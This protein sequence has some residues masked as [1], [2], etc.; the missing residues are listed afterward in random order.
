MSISSRCQRSISP[1]AAIAFALG[2]IAV[3]AAPD[4]V[5]PPKQELL[6]QHAV[7]QMDEANFDANVF[8]P[9]GNA[10]MARDQIEIR[11]KLQMDEL[12]RICELNDVQKQKLKLAATSDIKRFFDEVN[13]I[14]KKVVSGK[15]DQNEWNNVWQE[16]QPLRNKQ[17]AGL[18]GESSFYS[19]TVRKTLNPDQFA[20]Y[21]SVRDERRRFRYHACVEAAITSL[22]STIPLRQ[23]QHEAIARFLLETTEP[24]LVFTQYDST[25]ILY[26]LT[27]MPESRLKPILDEDQWKQ[28]QEYFKQYSGMEP[29][30][31]QNG[32]IPV[33]D[34][35]QKRRA[36]KAM[37]MERAQEHESPADAAAPENQAV[38]TELP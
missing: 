4:D 32:L 9:G 31:M 35:A 11:L 38:T 6:E 3:Q 36:P 27:Q 10:K 30:L 2:S 16:I 21:E 25:L 15:L 1:I 34:A 37:R 14:R 17:S 22:E 24:P 12:N 28:M 5:A 33:D 23:A 19:K 26:R 18:F 29:F 8:Q 20:R 13:T 7:F